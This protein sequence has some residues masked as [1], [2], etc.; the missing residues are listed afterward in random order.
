CGC[1]G[2]WNM[3][4]YVGEAVRQIKEQVGR[5]EVILGLSGGVDSSVAAALIHKAIGNQLTCVFVDHGLLR[6]NEAAQVMD[7][8]A[9]HMHVKVV[10]VDAAQEFYSALHGVSDP[11]QKRKIIGKHFVDVFQR[12][13]GKV[14]NAKW[15]A[16]GTIYPDVIESAG[17]KTKKAQT[18]KSH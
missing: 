12:E 3:P 10:H 7:T 1:R 6:L 8:F 4:D 11:E 17:A 14:R 2:D 16:Q 13:A 9:K 5:E 15:L 18:I